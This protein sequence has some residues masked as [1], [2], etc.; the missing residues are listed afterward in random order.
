MLFLV[1]EQIRPLHHD[2]RHDLT[3]P[4]AEE[5]LI[6]SGRFKVVN[7]EVAK[8]E[9]AIIFAV[10]PHAWRRVTVDDVFLQSVQRILPAQ[11]DGFFL[12]T[13]QKATTQ[14]YIARTNWNTNTAAA[15]PDDADRVQQQGLTWLANDVMLSAQ[16]QFQNPLLPFVV[17][18]GTSM[19]VIFELMPT[20]VA[21][22]IPNPFVI[23]N[24]GPNGTLRV[25]F[26]GALVVG[27]TMP[28]QVYDQLLKARR[29]GLLGP[30][31]G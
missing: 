1:D 27:L 11:G 28:K 31:A 26:A 5:L 6:S 20:A 3:D 13:V 2:E 14:P 8:N 21:G 12:F 17:A 10:V 24:P 25:D 7:I 4:A 16:Q 9:V 29:A 15:T 23:G 18:G 30:E 19:S 22:G